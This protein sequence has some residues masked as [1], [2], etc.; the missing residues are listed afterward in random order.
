[1]NY[2]SDY[3]NPV[4]DCIHSDRIFKRIFDDWHYKNAPGEG[5]RVST[6]AIGCLDCYTFMELPLWMRPMSEKML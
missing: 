4:V 2:I 3:A 5:L 1:M 6:R